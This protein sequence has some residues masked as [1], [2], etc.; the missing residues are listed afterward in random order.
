[1]NIEYILLGIIIGIVFL[2][3]FI[4]KIKKSR[5]NDIVSS[6]ETSKR[7]RFSIKNYIILI[8]G[9]ITFG[10]ISGGIYDYNYYYIISH[11]C[12]GKLKFYI[13][14]SYLENISNNYEIFDLINLISPGLLL[15]ICFYLLILNRSSFLEY[16]KPRKKN[17]TISILLITI[18]K[19]IIHFFLFTHSIRIGTSAVYNNRFKDVAVTFSEHIV[20]KKGELVFL[21]EMP[22]LFLVSLILYLLVVWFFNDKITAR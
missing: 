4:K 8:F 12:S 5:H 2:D 17:F 15:F 20:S 19:V 9:G 11:C 1:M 16:I 13:F 3:F 14:K 7:K 18:L 21:T 6:T 10:I 22:Q